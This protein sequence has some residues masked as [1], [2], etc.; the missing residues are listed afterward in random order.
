MRP[1]D[2][3]TEEQ[4]S[5]S[6][7]FFYFIKNG[8][9]LSQSVSSVQMPGYLKV[10]MNFFENLLGELSL[11]PYIFLDYGEEIMKLKVKTPFS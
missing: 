10:F 2:G 3:K 5:V 7:L 11:F 1:N 9:N 6:F 4:S 8:F